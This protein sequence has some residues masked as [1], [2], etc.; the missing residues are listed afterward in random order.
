MNTLLIVNFFGNQIYDQWSLAKNHQLWKRSLLWAS[1]PNRQTATPLFK[2]FRR[3]WISVVSFSTSRERNS[4][5]HR[6]HAFSTVKLSEHGHTIRSAT[7]GFEILRSLPNIA[8]FLRHFGG[9]VAIS[10]LASD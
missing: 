9:C 3:G 4:K 5:V 2:K 6:D 8:E 7:G 10:L 1:L